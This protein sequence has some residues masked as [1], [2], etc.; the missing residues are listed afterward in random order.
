M[1]RGTK[2]LLQSTYTYVHVYYN[3]IAYVLANNVDSDRTAHWN[4]L[5]RV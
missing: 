1:L 5:I 2:R 3:D 4:I